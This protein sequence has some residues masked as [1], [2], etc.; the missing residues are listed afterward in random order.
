VEAI[1]KRIS[2]LAGAIVL[3]LVALESASAGV[4]GPAKP[5]D[6]VT[7]ST[8]YDVHACAGGGLPNA[9]SIGSRLLSD[10]SIAVFTVPAKQVF[11]IISIEVQ[12]TTEAS[13]VS[14]T[15]R[16]GIPCG[17]GCMTS[18]AD[19]VVLTDA[20]GIGSGTAQFPLGFPVKPS[21]ALCVVDLLGSMDTTATVRGYFT[22]DR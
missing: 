18:I 3:V 9:R 19:V 16:V 14:N 10:G 1:M 22:K 12:A 13:F 17:P 8:I 2:M 21:V 20:D 7:I 11:V 5:S 6:L 4:L 15:V